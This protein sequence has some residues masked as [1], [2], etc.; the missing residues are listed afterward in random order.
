MDGARIG[1]F[2]HL[3]LNVQ[4]FRFRYR[5]KA[6]VV[7]RLK[8]DRDLPVRIISLHRRH[9]EELPSAG[10]IQWVDARLGTADPHPSPRDADARSGKAGRMDALIQPAQISDAR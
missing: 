9:A 1:A 3:F 2:V 5:D 10:G 4:I 8:E 7:A 6:D